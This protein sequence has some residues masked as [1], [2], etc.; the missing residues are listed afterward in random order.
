MTDIPILFSRPMVQRILGGRK[1]QTR[2]IIKPQPQGYHCWRDEDNGLWFS[3]GYGQAGDWL[4]NL[5]WSPS[6]RLWV[7]ESGHLLT[8]PVKSDARGKDIWE[9]V[10]WKHAA[11]DT[12]IGY[13]GHQPGSWLGECHSKRKPSIHMPRWASRITLLVTDVRVQRVQD[14]T[15]AD[16]ISEGFPPYANS[17][18]IDCETPNPRD[19]FVRVWRK[20][21]GP[22]SWD[23]NPWVAAITF[24]AEIRN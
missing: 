5:R 10:G 14:I 4:L 8:A 16:A 11:D 12:V 13:N 19:D 21:N 3:S 9:I 2:R 18:T 7:R 20:T 22:E 15:P 24:D 6:D 17:Q 23:A 1:T